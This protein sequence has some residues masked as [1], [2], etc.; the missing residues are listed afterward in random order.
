MTDRNVALRFLA[1]E[2]RVELAPADAERLGLGDGDEVEV[3]SNGT[4]VRARVQLRERLRPGAAYLIEG[5][6]TDNANVFSRVRG[7]EIEKR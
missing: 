1:P 5:T 6:A 4:G 7:V 3:R 2:Q